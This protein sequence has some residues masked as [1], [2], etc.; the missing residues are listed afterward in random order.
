MV[1]EV[2]DLGR[3]LAAVAC[4]NHPG[5]EAGEELRKV[6]DHVRVRRVVVEAS[7]SADEDAA[8]QAVEPARPA[9]VAV[10]VAH[11]GRRGH[12]SGLVSRWTTSPVLPL[13]DQ[14]GRQ[15]EHD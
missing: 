3:G 1:L 9:P 2:E 4:A 8:R 7:V 10:A 15:E 11:W 12:F 13:A 6:A 5:L 14:E